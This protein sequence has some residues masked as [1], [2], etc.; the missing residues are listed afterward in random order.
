MVETEDD[1]KKIAEARIKF[2]AAAIDFITN[3]GDFINGQNRS[4]EN[5]IAS[6]AGAAKLKERHLKI[7]LMNDVIDLGNEIRIALFRAQALR[8]P[9]ILE[10][11]MPNFA[12]ISE[13]IAKMRTITHQ[14]R[15]IEQLD[16]VKKAAEAY[17]TNLNIL[18]TNWSH[19][20]Q[21]NVKRTEVGNKVLAAAEQTA[22]AGM[23]QT[24]GIAKTAAIAMTAASTLNDNRF[25]SFYINWHYRSLRNYSK[26]YKT[27]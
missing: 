14:A 3:C 18:V 13:K 8:D 26:H 9:K 6:N 25:V 2:D 12:L 4:M 24:S 17:Q 19:L 27:N 23:E 20:Q 5:E 10:E 7:V 21:I 16:N 11:K 1:I 15:N 22:I